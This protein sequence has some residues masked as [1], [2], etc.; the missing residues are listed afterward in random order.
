ME[1]ENL[2]EW[3]EVKLP[4]PHHKDRRVR[5]VAHIRKNETGEVRQ[6]ETDAIM[7]LGEVA[8]DEFWWSEGNAGCDCNRSLFFYRAIGEDEPEEPECG[9]GRFSVNLQ[10]PVTGQ[11]Y[12]TEF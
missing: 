3:Q 5:I 2:S 7:E 6:Y 4:P 9:E 12:Y 10:N 8:P 1:V 11:F